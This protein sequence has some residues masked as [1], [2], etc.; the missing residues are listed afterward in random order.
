MTQQKKKGSVIKKIFRDNWKEVLVL[1]AVVAAFGLLTLLVI[2]PAYK[3]PGNGTASS[4]LGYT[5]LLRKSGKAIP[6][7]SQQVVTEKIQYFVMG[8]GVCA[9]QPVL[10]PIIPMDRVD[11]VYVKEGEW[12]KAGQVLARLSETKAKIKLESAKLAESTASAELERVR[13]GSAYVLAQERPEVEKISLTAMEQ[14]LSFSKEKLER[15]ETAFEKGV[16][17][18]VVLLEARK[19]FTNVSEGFEQAQLS[20]RMAEQG[21][22]QSLKI[23][24]NAVGDAEQAVAHR[25]EELRQ[26]TVYAPVDGIVDRVLVQAGEYNQDSGKPGFL[27]SSGFWFDAYFDQADYAFVQQGQK[28]SVTLESYPGRKWPAE[29]EMVKPVVSF[30]SGGP[31]ISRPLRPRGSGSPEWAATFKVQIK[32]MTDVLKHRI[33]TGMTGFTRLEIE[34]ESVVV[35]RSAILSLSAGSALVYLPKGESWETREVTVGH[36]GGKQVEILDGLKLGEQVLIEGHLNLKLDDKI[37]VNQK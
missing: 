19:D 12:V 4:R 35:P 18:R 17:S 9:S 26:Y 15:Y 23:A 8:E 1:G 29:I 20:M 16:I 11:E 33:V 25:E 22:E 31:E 30:N 32:L 14:Q 27:L 7:V 36:V 13:L 34:R 3:S 24:M 10:V 28:C 21:V 5:E 37:S 6:V 2:I